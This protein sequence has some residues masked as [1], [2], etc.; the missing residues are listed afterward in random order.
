MSNCSPGSGKDWLINAQTRT[1]SGIDYESI[2][3]ITIST[4]STNLPFS[5]RPFPTLNI[6]TIPTFSV[7]AGIFPSVNGTGYPT[8]GYPTLPPLSVSAGIFPSANGTGYPTFPSSGRP[9]SGFFPLPTINLTTN[10]NASV[11]G[12]PPL[13]FLNI[14]GPGRLPLPLLN[15][16]NKTLPIPTGVTF[17]AS[18]LHP[19]LIRPSGRIPF[20]IANLTSLIPFLPTGTAPPFS[21]SGRPVLPLNSSIFGNATVS[22]ATLLPVGAQVAPTSCPGINNHIYTVPGTGPADQ[23]QFKCFVEYTGRPYQDL[24]QLSLPECIAE[25]SNINAVFS[26]L[27]CFGV[28]YMQNSTGLHCTLL[29][30]AALNSSTVNGAAISAVLATSVG[31]S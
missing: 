28:S 29:A 11:S 25:C 16:T 30:Q 31:I 15:G 5:S 12:R 9:S 22:N 23:Y 3:T 14:T 27:D 13:P 18:D 24:E 1:I 20:L 26:R 2:G 10:F 6:S 8:T 17:P 21:F 19:V 4:N 7:S